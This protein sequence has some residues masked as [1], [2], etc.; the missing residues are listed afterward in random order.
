V[1][2]VVSEEGLREYFAAI[3][4]REEYFS[5]RQSL[6]DLPAIQ[7]RDRKNDLHSQVSNRI[8]DLRCRIVHSKEDGGGESVD[9]LLPF[10]RE[11]A[12]IWP[13]IELLRFLAREA[14]ICGAREMSL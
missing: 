10:S 3:P 7:L 1:Q 8:Y 14:L 9:L 11:V 6:K 5:G 4:E 13:D 2:G 12:T